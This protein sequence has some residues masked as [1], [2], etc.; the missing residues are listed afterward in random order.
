MAPR[1]T[2]PAAPRTT[3]L[4]MDAERRRKRRFSVVPSTIAKS[5]NAIRA[6]IGGT[7]STGCPVR[8]G[9]AFRNPRL[10]AATT[11]TR[12]SL[13]SSSRPDRPLCHR[14]RFYKATLTPRARR[15]VVEQRRVPSWPRSNHRRRGPSTQCCQPTPRRPRQ[16]TDAGP[17]PP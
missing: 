14:L 10:A 4:H 16:I 7:Q 9:P 3:E 15:H 5:R 11:A 2:R 1:G 8:Y 12:W 13:A 17:A 6:T